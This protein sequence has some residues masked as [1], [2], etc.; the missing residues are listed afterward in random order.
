M[1]NDN[2]TILS[3]E[4]LGNSTQAYDLVANSI[5]QSL[6]F[7]AYEGKTVFNAVVLTHP[8]ILSELD[9]NYTGPTEAHGAHRVSEFMFKAR[10]LPEEGIPSP[11]DY[12]PDPCSINASHADAGTMDFLMH[13]ISLHTTFYSATQ[14]ETIEGVVKPKVGDVVRVELERN[15][16]SYN[17]ATGTF[18]E[19]ITDGSL[20]TGTAIDEETG[21][22]GPAEPGD[23]N[24]C[25]SLSNIFNLANSTCDPH[26][27]NGT[28][29]GCFPAGFFSG[30]GLS[31]GGGPGAGA[32]AAQSGEHPY[33]LA[34]GEASKVCAPTQGALTSVYGPRVHPVTG[35][36]GTMHWGIDIAARPR[37]TCCADKVDVVAIADGQ[38]GQKSFNGNNPGPTSGIGNNIRIYHDV[39]VEG[40]STSPPPAR[41]H[42]SRYGHLHTIEDWVE[43]GARVRCGQ[44]IGT[45]G[46]TGGSTGDHLHFEAKRDGG[47]IGDPIQFFGWYPCIFQGVRSGLMTPG[48]KCGA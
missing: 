31:T 26:G 13:A 6:I 17:L 8:V 15:S 22:V 7:N 16:F 25:Q 37:T 32:I 1:A 43:V 14:Q 3:R 42:S 34:A 41:L 48:Q 47:S 21:R 9:L 39:S 27:M 20:T 45:M 44:K 12:I 24:E 46:T 30:T 38:I 29:G 40:S 18:L 10:I 36:H 19:V 4:L 23:R 35:V 33:I 2:R 11:H 28:A 5:R